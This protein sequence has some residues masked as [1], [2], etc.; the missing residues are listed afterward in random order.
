MMEK[1]G[2]L[3]GTFDPVHFGHL[4]AAEC[5]RKELGLSRVI[6]LPS[7]MPPHKKA[8]ISTIR[9]RLRM[10]QLSLSEV[11]NA[12]ISEEDIRKDGPSYTADTLERL[13]RMN[14]GTEYWFISGSDA[15]L[16]MPGWIHAEKLFKS[17][18]V[19]VLQRTG[20]EDDTNRITALA[21]E[22]LMKYGTEVRILSADI[23]DISGTVIRKAV[24]KGA[25]I[26]AF[27]PDA[28]ARLI[29]EKGLYRDDL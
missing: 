16:R 11:G 28:V 13:H 22:L 8:G 3:G 27:V 1:A 19:A 5:A 10:L 20:Q 29:E 18:S 17:V 14:P 6:F 26:S 4:K 9:E 7:G 24:K 25:G 15:F 12:E 23:P 21:E 2:I